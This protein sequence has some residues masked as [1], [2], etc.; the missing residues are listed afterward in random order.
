MSLCITCIAVKYLYP[1]TRNRA[2]FDSRLSLAN[3]GSM[4]DKNNV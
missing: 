2:S 3:R 4:N 1:M